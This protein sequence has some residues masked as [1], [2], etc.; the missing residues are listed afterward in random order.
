MDNDIITIV[1]GTSMGIIYG[2]KWDEEK[3]KNLK[4][5]SIISS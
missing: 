3:Y 5:T 1:V 2:K 4:K